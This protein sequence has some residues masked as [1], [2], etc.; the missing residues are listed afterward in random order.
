MSIE[1]EP[2]EEIPP[3]ADLLS[4]AVWMVFGAA[5]FTGAWRMDRLASQGINKYE[6]PG[7]VPGLLGAMVFVLGALLAARS[8]RR[9]ALHATDTGTARTPA[10]RGLVGVFVATLL[11]PLVL[12]GH[13]I[14]FWLATA[15]F[16]TAFIFF[17]DRARQTA[18]GRSTGKQVL[19]ALTCGVVTSAVVSL[20]FERVFYVRLP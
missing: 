13:G 18:L 8:I 14:P 12:V 4:A 19:V 3:R 1:T 20:V 2:A 16:V 9:G 7:L 11:Y 17:F 15:V 5:V 10:D 6:I